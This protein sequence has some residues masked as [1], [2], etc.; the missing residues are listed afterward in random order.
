M[1][2]KIVSICSFALLSLCIGCGQKQESSDLTK[3]PSEE[4]V[5]IGAAG[6]AETAVSYG[7]IDN[8]L[9]EAEVVVY[10][11]AK[12]Y[13]YSVEDGSVSTIETVE[14][15]DC[16]YGD[17]EQGDEISVFKMGG[18]A[19][20]KDYFDSYEEQFRDQVRNSIPFADLSDEEIEGKYIFFQ[21]T[22]DV[23]TDVGNKSVFFLKKS[24]TQ[25]DIY[26]RIGSYEG[27]YVEL[28]NGDFKVPGSETY[29]E[30]ENAVVS[31][32]VNTE[33]LEACI[34]SWDEIIRQI[35]Q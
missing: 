8:L 10:G 7:S 5:I 26:N 34:I 11:E 35:E 24:D 15:L 9:A 2:K 28:S 30:I 16:L 27:E 33:G 20:L 32:T 22:G 23:N 25:E 1:Q 29:E 17:M 18:Y 6:T 13:T 21:P 14:V 12:S 31:D 3:R 19:R 4:D